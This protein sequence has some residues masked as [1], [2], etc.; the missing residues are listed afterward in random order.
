MALVV[1][2][3]GCARAKIKNETVS[4]QPGTVTKSTLILVKRISA[5]DAVFT[6][7]KADDTKRI[8]D[9]KK[10][11]KTTLTEDVVG[12]MKKRGLNAQVYNDKAPKGAVVIEGTVVRFE[13]GSGA[14]RALVGMGAGSSNMVTRVKAHKDNETVSEFEVI[15]TSGGRGGL[16]SMS[17]FLEAHLIDASEKIAEYVAERAK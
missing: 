15:A 6:G 8:N 4:L 10:I 13:H 17:S 3:T 16:N 7:D 9:E 12:Q 11:I 2:I 14:A 1:A 5:D